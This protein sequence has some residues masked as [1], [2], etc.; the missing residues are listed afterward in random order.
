MKKRISAIILTMAIAITLLPST[1]FAMQVFVKV[2]TED[3][4]ITLEVEPSDSIENI[5]QK[6]QDKE[7]IPPEKQTLVYE[8]MLL[9]DGNTLADYNI[10]KESTILLFVYSLGN[11]GWYVNG[12]SPSYTVSTSEDMLGLA[13]LANIGN[14]NTVYYDD[15]FNVFSVEEGSAG[16]ISG[17]DFAGKTVTIASDIILGSVWRPIGNDICPFRGT[18]DGN[19]KSI[20]GLYIN[21]PH[22]FYQGLFGYIED[23]QVMNVTVGEGSI[24]GDRFLGGIAGYSLDSEISNC[25]NYASLKTGCAE[26]GGII[27]A[28]D[29]SSDI[30]KDI[31][32]AKDCANFGSVVCDYY[33]HMHCTGGIIGVLWNDSSTYKAII[34]GCVN[35]GSITSNIAGT[36]G[37]IGWA[38]NAVIDNCEN[39]GDV[40]GTSEVGGIAGCAESCTILNCCNTADATVSG[41]GFSRDK[42]GSASYDYAYANYVGG[43]IGW[44]D[45]DLSYDYLSDTSIK[46]C[47]NAGAIINTCNEDTAATG[48]IAG[49]IESHDGYENTIENCY[50]IGEVSTSI[51]YTGDIGAIAGENDDGTI[52]K[53][54]WLT[55]LSLSAAGT[56]DADNCSAFTEAQGKSE[57][58]TDFTQD[59]DGSLLTALNIWVDSTE[60][61]TWQ[62]AAT[63][64]E[65]NGYPVFGAAFEPTYSISVNPQSEDF[66]SL[67][68]GYAAAPQAKTITIENTGNQSITIASAPTASDFTVSGDFPMTILAGSTDT[69]TVQPKLS[70]AVGTYEETIS[71]IGSNDTSALLTVQFEVTQ[72]PTYSISITP[73]SEDFG[74]LTQGY[75]AAPQAKTITIENTGNK[76]IT[77][78]SAPTASD[79]TLSGDFPMTI[80]AG[81]SDT[82]TVQPKISLAVGTYEE[83]ISII[84]TND[85]SASLTVQFEVT[86]APLVVYPITQGANGSYQIGGQ[87]GLGF[88]SNGDF[89][90]IQSVAVN[91]VLID[92]G[93]YTAQSNS[94]TLITLNSAYLDTFSNGT[95]TLRINFTDGYSETTFTI[96]S[97]T[98]VP[99][100]PT[101][102]TSLAVLIILMIIS[103]LTLK[104]CIFCKEKV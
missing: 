13:I 95:H 27:G 21:S 88:T 62:A 99:N 32:V 85:T 26:I 25:K 63:E 38:V 9:Y 74:S 34:S 83:T 101:G 59:E 53:C 20:D 77:I 41:S 49:H 16:S 43:I 60:Y 33:E 93:S 10:Q 17:T 51:G 15:D 54:Y 24:T 48:G 5:K 91:G 75:A 76:S 35:S 19:N 102:D 78:A 50:N 37:I 2:Q 90:K 80:L 8:D 104:T 65:N 39:S 28:A 94:G 36:G 67:T 79:F 96:T 89:A 6:I 12:V 71:I 64:T 23:A 87:T 97:D 47:Y 44:T 66:G 52:T 103:A 56:G 98:T 55:D 100:P 70:L 22:T 81:S 92:A 86:A 72:A 1:V 4:T 29:I 30:D 31:N 73:Q 18:F 58:E 14:E 84:G 46:N 45:I 68:Q 40:T 57:S 42:S 3:K 61:L 82:F 7:G 69:F 11:I